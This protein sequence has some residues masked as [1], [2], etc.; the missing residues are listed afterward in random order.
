MNNLYHISYEKERLDILKLI[1]IIKKDNWIDSSTILV[2]CSP[3]YSSF[4]SQLINHKLSYL[5]NNELY[6]NLFLEMPY[7]IMSQVWDREKLEI[8]SFDTYLKEWVNKYLTNS[9]KY[10]FIDSATIRGRNFSKVKYSINNKVEYKFASLYVEEQSI[11]IPDYYVEKYNEE[12][13]GELIFTRENDNNPNWK[14][15]KKL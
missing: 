13:K 6:E 9:L 11:L 1:E 12:E 10:L 5:N 8:V 15:T 7:P 2:T 3:D 4:V 14:K